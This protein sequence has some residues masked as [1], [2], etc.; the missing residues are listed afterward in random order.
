MSGTAG[1]F[2]ATAGTVKAPAET[3]AAQPAKPPWRRSVKQRLA[4]G[5]TPYLFV[6]PGLAVYVVFVL[7][8]LLGAFGL[9]LTNWS[10]TGPIHFDG[11]SNY[12]R[13]FHDGLAAKA[14]EHTAIY[15]AGTTVAKLVLAL[16]LALL[17]NQATRAIRA[18]RTILFIPALLSFVAVGIL[19]NWIYSPSFG[20]INH[21]LS[22]FGV[23]TSHLTWL[24]S[25]SQALPA[26]MI[27]EVWKWTGYHMVIFLAGLQTIPRELPEAAMVDG[28]GKI[29]VLWRI[30][31]PMLKPI[32]VINFIIAV[33]GSLNVFD[34]VY[35]TTQGGPYNSTQT[36]MT[37]VYQQAFSDFSFGYAAA[38]AVLLF[39]GVAVI[40]I[41][42][43]R[44]LRSSAYT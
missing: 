3:L 2:T 19:W 23:S 25:A 14:F 20:L 18:Y 16:G 29:R 10:G 6:L 39:I 17:A 43:L 5:M 27:V 30:T 34:L 4:R 36:V 42:S 31:L 9:S 13:I 28:A 8:P 11:I 21:A 44:A 40:T 22:V 26:L 7:L 37:Y 33:A 38:L 32:T 35:V 41:V 24:G 1:R 12:I 15:A